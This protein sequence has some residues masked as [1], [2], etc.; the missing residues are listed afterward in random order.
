MSAASAHELTLPGSPE[1]VPAAR[2]FVRRAL[3]DAATPPEG[4]ERAT[5]AVSELVTNAVIHTR[6]PV[7]VRVRPGSV[8]R[9]EVED[10]GGPLPDTPAPALPLPVVS[11]ERLAPGGL[12]LAL[13]AAIASR[14]GVIDT[15]GPGKVVWFEV[16]RSPGGDGSGPGAGTATDV[17]Q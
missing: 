7:R 5:L 6:T 14:W 8:S 4:V 10:Q 15:T 9:V 16:E 1:S 2:A 3:G 12:G 17:T 13:V 11:A